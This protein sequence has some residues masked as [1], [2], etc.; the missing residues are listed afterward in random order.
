LNIV[1]TVGLRK[2]YGPLVALAGVDLE[3]PAGS[4]YGLV[5]PNGA[6]KTTLLEILAGLRRQSGGDVD[7]GATREAIAYCPDVAEF[8]PWLSA[9]EVLEAALGL[10]G[11]RR[12]RSELEALLG[13]VGLG[14]V[15]WRRVGGFSH[16]MTT[17]LNLAAALV[18]EPQVLILDEPASSLDP[19]GRVEVLELIAALAPATTVLLSSHDLAE[20]EAICEHV[21]ILS[22]GRL[23]YQGALSE[24]LAGAARSRWTI[25]VRP[26]TTPA[27]EAL[28]AAPWVS[29]L[30]ELAPGELELSAPDP[31]QV[32]EHLVPV[33]ARCGSRVVSISP[34]R[35]SLQE[36]FL[37]LT[38][39]QALP[40]DGAG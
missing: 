21:G 22:Q 26:P 23:I 15:A 10:I 37:S 9:I 6:G 30:S 39:A 13:K 11:R 28:K 38:V 3:V 27:V 29:S 33:L 5:G 31:T 19:A 4:L 32:E 17:R 14:E 24:L 12:P 1:R 35:P 36:V 8:E 34:R 18:G 25:V 16:G 2:S 7:L 20:I 40:R